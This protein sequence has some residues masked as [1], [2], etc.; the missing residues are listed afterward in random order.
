MH[1]GGLYLKSLSGVFCTLPSTI[2][3]QCTLYNE[4]TLIIGVNYTPNT[5][6]VMME[7]TPFVGGHH[8][9]SELSVLYTLSSFYSVL[10]YIEHVSLVSI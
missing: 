6:K 8:M 9:C 7:S 2:G 5:E 4:N 1:C 10:L 3:V